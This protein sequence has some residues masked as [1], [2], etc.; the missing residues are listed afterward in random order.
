MSTAENPRKFIGMKYWR[1]PVS[2]LWWVEPRFE[3]Q[4][5]N[6][7]NV[8]NGFESG[9]IPFCSNFLWLAKRR[10]YRSLNL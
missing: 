6:I 4:C 10:A 3:Y 8:W 9:G 1:N 5:N 2:N 7:W